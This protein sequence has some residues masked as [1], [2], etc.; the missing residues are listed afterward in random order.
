MNRWKSGLLVALALSAGSAFAQ[1]K[2]ALS[3]RGTASTQVGGKWAVEKAGEEPRYS[4]GKWIDI[5]YGRPIKRGRTALFGSGASYGAKLNAGAPV[6]RVGANAT[7][8][9]TTEAALDIAG[10]KIPAGEYD[11]FV[12]LKE[13]GWTLILSTQPTQSKY[14]PADKSAIWGSYGYDRKYDVVRA[15]MKMVKP[16][17]SIDQFTISF[18]DMTDQGG[19]IGMAWDHEGAVV[20]FSVA[21]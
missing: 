19:K 16:A 21:P 7:T 20:E 2:R 17:F 12:E 11:V 14:D 4:G 18:L 8:K 1:E 3:P 10:K 13:G 6:W 15:P 9:L 5:D